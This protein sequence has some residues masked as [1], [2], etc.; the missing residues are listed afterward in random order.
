LE[1]L[2]ALVT[3]KTRAVIAVN[4][5]NPTG[6]YLSAAEISGLDAL[7]VKHGLA[8]IVDEVFFDYQRR[9]VSRPMAT[10]LNR[11]RCLTFVLNGLSKMLGLPQVKLGWIALGGDEKLVH[12]AS[13]GLEVL[14]DFYLSVGTP[15]Q[16]AV[17]DLLALRPLLQDRIDSR[18]AV[19]ARFLSE[20]VASTP[21]CRELER[22]GGWYAVLA[23]TD[24][25]TDEQ[26]VLRLLEQ[27]DTLVH[28][29]FFYDF[30]QDGYAVISLLPSTDCFQDGLC[31]LLQLMMNS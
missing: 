9:P 3:S 10:A 1:V 5:N 20:Q 25:L 15:V 24:A 17:P 4:P 23:F 7:C 8:L 21:G 14:L 11:C 31:R 6:S 2:A 28:P 18:L 26:R 12:Q 19:N 27:F 29:G 13:R 22:Q 16:H 30:G